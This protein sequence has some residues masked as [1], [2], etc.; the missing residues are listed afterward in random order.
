MKKLLAISLL[1]LYLLTLT[2]VGQ[3]IKLPLLVDHFIEHKEK[4][5][6]LSLLDFLAMHYSHSHTPDADDLKLPFKSHN[7]C[8]SLNIWPTE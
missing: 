2:E 3:L 4:D 7:G 6:N 8:I 5:Q 1:S